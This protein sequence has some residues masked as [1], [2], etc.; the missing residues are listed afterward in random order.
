MRFTYGSPQEKRLLALAFL[1][2]SLLG[3][4]FLRWQGMFRLPFLFLPAYFFLCGLLILRLPLPAADRSAV[5]RSLYRTLPTLLFMGA[6]FLGSNLSMSSGAGF[7]IRDIYLHF[8]EFFALG[9][10]TA[11]MVSPFRGRDG[12]LSSLFLAVGI[13]AVF[14]GLDEIHQIYV[15]G[16][17]PDFRDLAWDVMGGLTGVLAYLLFAHRRPGR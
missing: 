13:V 5:A 16:R 12:L 10:L 11:R 2:A 9:L 6:I 4:G 14:A 15:P 17:N 1:L 8:A 3:A 7:S